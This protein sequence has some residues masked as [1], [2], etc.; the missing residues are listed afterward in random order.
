MDLMTIQDSLLDNRKIAAVMC[1][2]NATYSNKAYACLVT[3]EISVL[4]MWIPVIIGIPYNWKLDL[5][6][7]YVEDK[8][9]FP[10]IPHIDTKGKVC[11]FDL[12]GILIDPNLCGLLNQ[13]IERAIHVISDGLTGKNRSDFLKEFDLYWCQLPGIRAIKF[14]VPHEKQM[15]IIHYAEKRG[16]QRS[17][18]SYA[19]YLQRTNRTGLFGTANHLDFTTWNILDT[20][21]NGIYVYIQAKTYIM[22]PDARKKL[23]ID[24]INSL[25]CLADSHTFFSVVS[26]VGNDKVLLFEV[27]QPNNIKICIGVMIRNGIFSKTEDDKIYVKSYSILQPLSVRRVDKKYLMSRTSDECNILQAKKYL[28]IGC[29]SI[30]GYVLNEMV[31]SGCEDITLVDSDLLKEE[32]VFRHLLGI[33]YVDEYKAEAL[34]N[35]FGKNISGIRLKP[36]DGE[37]ENLVYDGDVDLSDYDIIISAVGNNN[38]NRWLNGYLC[39]N[40][41]EISVIYAWNEPLDIGCHVAYIRISHEG[42]YECFFGRDYKTQELY[43]MTAYCERGQQITK[44][45]SGCG[46]SFIPYGSTVSLKSAMMSIDLLKKVVSGRCVEN[47]LISVKGEGYYYEKAGLKTSDVFKNQSESILT[48]KGNEFVNINCGI[49]GSCYGI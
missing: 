37:I 10:F 30:G 42:C 25:L 40:A 48:V 5:M 1:K 36:L 16:K 3:C 19:K 43:D 35:Y 17:K 2:K 26:K 24:Y 11:L 38:V 12:E 8:D 44:N 4:D 6:D 32:N 7:V 49:C 29:G 33:E 34:T 46:G 41:L 31:K 45:L 14:S 21:K 13:C 28:M 9:N 18:E 23:G 22:P 20:R 39:E 47:V 27:R 15:Q